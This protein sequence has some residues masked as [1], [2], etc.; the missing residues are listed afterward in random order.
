M[1]AADV[2]LWPVYAVAGWVDDNPLSAVGVVVALGALA[3]FFGTAGASTGPEGAALAYEG[4]TLA[5]VSE[6]ALAQPA[7]VV[8]ALVGLAVFVLYDG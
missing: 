5:A 1:G 3:V 4:I 6:T 2:L 8:A 7:Y